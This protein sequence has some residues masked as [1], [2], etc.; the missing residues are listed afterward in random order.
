[1]LE[2][3]SKNQALQNSMVSPRSLLRRSS[4][5]AWY[6]FL[7]EAFCRSTIEEMDTLEAIPMAAN[8]KSLCRMK[9]QETNRS[10]IEEQ[11]QLSDRTYVL[12]Q[13]SLP[14][15]SSKGAFS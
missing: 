14:S 7:Q 12:Q 3:K 15:G 4:Q 11:Q 13:S 1:M 10:K 2:R 5:G 8:D 9:N 6:K